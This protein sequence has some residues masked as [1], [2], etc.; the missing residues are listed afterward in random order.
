[1]KSLDVKAL[2]AKTA[3]EFSDE[4]ISAKQIEEAYNACIHKFSMFMRQ[5]KAVVIHNFG[6]FYLS[7]RKILRTMFRLKRKKKEGD[8]DPETYKSWMLG[9]YWLFYRSAVHHRP[10]KGHKYK[11][12]L[13][14]GKN[15]A[16]IVANEE[17][18]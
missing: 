15:E 2:I 4:G 11:W 17:W 16:E 12:K 8:L 14:E 10:G 3:E 5:R 7:R 13:K 1:M 9:R 18:E 6:R